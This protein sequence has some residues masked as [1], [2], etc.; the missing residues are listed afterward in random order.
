MYCSG[1][2]CP[3]SCATCV[4]YSSEHAGPFFHGQLL[5][6]IG[7]DS[8]VLVHAQ[9]VRIILDTQVLIHAQLVRSILDTHVLIRAQ[10]VRII[11]D[12]QVLIHAQPVRIIL[13]TQVLIHARLVRIVLDTQVLTKLD[14]LV[15]QTSRPSFQVADQASG[16]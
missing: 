12:T 14:S 9:L 8:Q 16:G 13:D 4:L 1:L 11:L 3:Y 2:K 10:L 7:L 5:R 15:H 6:C